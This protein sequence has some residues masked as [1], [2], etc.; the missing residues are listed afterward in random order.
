MPALQ[1]PWL[2]ALLTYI[3]SQRDG[4]AARRAA[5][6]CWMC[7]PVYLLFAF[8]SLGGW[9]IAVDDPTLDGR[10]LSYSTLYG[11]VMTFAWVAAAVYGM[12]IDNLRRPDEGFARLILV[13][14][15]ATTAFTCY[16]VGTL[17]IISGLV[18]M[19][20]PLLGL[21]LFPIAEI[22][23]LFSVAIL[24]VLGA[25]VASSLGMLPYA[26]VLNS[27]LTTTTAPGLYYA[28]SGIVG[29]AL[30]VAYEVLVM[31]ALVS[32]SRFHESDARAQAVTDPLTGLAN[33]RQILD[34][35]ERLLMRSDGDEKMLA[36]IVV[37]IDDFRRINE[38]HGHRTG[39]H[40]LVTTAWALR[41][42]LRNKDLIG[43]FDGEEFL[44][45]LPDT[46]PAAAQEVA[47]RCRLAV[48]HAGIEVDGRRIELSASVGV[49]VCTEQHVRDVDHLIRR[50]TQAIAAARANGPDK[51]GMG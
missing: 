26:P 11:F 30:Y 38:E 39:D 41:N 50:A 21:M 43:R 42:C 23:A 40:V 15:A 17:N 51:I 10:I 47:E 25:S 14:Y 1:Q 9:F 2:T 4:S 13:G 44:V 20:A 49:A 12:Q 46:R 7:V 31:A 19:G 29:S 35:L 18:M 45:I 48:R 34:E 36:A 22:L 27:G 24:A 5:F 8:W 3:G 28:M 6:V 16:L 37:D 33:R 32:T